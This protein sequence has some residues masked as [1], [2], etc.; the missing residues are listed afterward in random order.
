LTRKKQNEKNMKWRKRK[1]YKVWL[2]V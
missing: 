1:R 2:R